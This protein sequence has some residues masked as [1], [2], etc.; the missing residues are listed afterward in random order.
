M[1][2][3]FLLAIL[4]LSWSPIVLAQEPPPTPTEE[5]D[6][7]DTDGDTQFLIEN[8]VEDSES[9]EFDFG[10]EFDYLEVYETNPLDLNTATEAEFNEF[11]LL[12]ALQIQA[13]MLYRKKYGQI[14]SLYEL[15]GVPT[16]DLKSIMRI[17]P[18]VAISK[19]KEREKMNFGRMFQY[20]RHQIFARWQ[21]ILEQ[22]KGFSTQN[23]NR[24]LGS[25]DKFYMRYRMTYK[26]RMSIG[27]TMEKDAGEEFFKGS[28]KQGFD[29]YSGH[30]Y[31]KEVTKNIHSVAIGDFQA[32]FGQGLV[33]WGGFGI[34][35]GADVLNVKRISLP[36][37]PYTSVNEALFMRGAAGHFQFLE[38]NALE[39]TVFGSHRFRDANLS[40]ELDSLTQELDFAEVSSL[41]QLGFH[42][43]PNELGNENTTQLFTT[44]GRV[45]YKGNSWY[46][47]GNFV[48][49][50]LTNPLVRNNEQPYQKYQFAGNETFNGSV[51]YSFQYKNMQFFGETAINEAGGIATIN[52]ILSD[53]DPRVGIALVHRYYSEKYQTLNGG[54][55]AES[56]RPTNE[57]GFYIGLQTNFGKGVRMSS[58]FDVFEFPWLRFLTDAPSRG[59]EV[60]TKLEYNPNYKMSAYTQYRFERKGRNISGNTTNIDQLINNDKQNL[61]FHF[62]YNVSREFSL[63]SRLEFAWYQ[64]ENNS[65]GVMVYQD[66][67][68]TPKNFP[69]KAQVRLAFFQTD[70]FNTRIYAYENDILYAF[71]VLPY[72]G[73][74]MRYYLNLSYKINR[75]FSVWL[76]FSQ[77]YF[78]DRQTISSGLGEIDKNTRSEV[79]V[80]IR[81]KF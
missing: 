69:L 29:F 67:A 10:N 30:F 18:Y 19:S 68:Y 33:M 37:R 24:F 81:A 76:R 4:L 58:Y 13:L 14:Y 35:K 52:S 12:S 59:Y 34:R 28:N 45:R 20:G 25:P 80:Q 44:G 11:G 27:V 1:I 2:R 53:L 43:T 74:G 77:T 48:Y 55:F 22:Q 60:F 63:R 71:S 6:E 42:R 56:T 72:Y 64:N 73:Q 79:K 62:Q 51:D 65:K 26:D 66:I 47:A 50:Y 70:D 17:L 57:H 7:N 38:E 3:F 9:E 36:I 46:V 15:Q 16:Y 8:L 49:N 21:R 78:T 39:V 75:N 40:A 23:D 5:P 31:L 54:A 41:Q 61:R 32:Y